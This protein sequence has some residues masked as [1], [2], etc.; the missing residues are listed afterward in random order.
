MQIQ[1]FYSDPVPSVR[2]PLDSIVLSPHTLKGN[3]FG[4]ADMAEDPGDYQ[5]L[6]P[7]LPSC[8]LHDQG[9]SMEVNPILRHIVKLYRQLNRRCGH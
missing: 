2:N 4:L 9:A 1:N 8:E 6:L 7:S 5:S 3:D